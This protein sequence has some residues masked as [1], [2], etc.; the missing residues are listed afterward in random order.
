MR[1][2][3]SL[4]THGREAVWGSYSGRAPEGMLVPQ[5]FLGRP[6]PP[7]FPGCALHLPGY[8]HKCHHFWGSA[9]RCH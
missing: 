5:R 6:T 3:G 4:T 8:S 2:P 1:N 7:V 9:G